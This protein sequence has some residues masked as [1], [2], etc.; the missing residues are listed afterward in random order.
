MINPQAQ[1]SNSSKQRFFYGY[2][3]VVVSFCIIL[4]LVGTQFSFGIFFKPVL[5]EFG[6]TRA[7]TS[8]AFSLSMIINGLLCIVMGGFNDKFGPR[9]V[10]TLCGFIFGLGYLLMSRVNTIWQLYLFYGV[11]IGIGMSGLWVPTMSTVARW[12]TRR[13]GT[14]TGIVLGGTG[15][16]TFILSQLASRLIA[17]YDWRISYI[18]IGSFVLVVLVALAQLLRRDPAQIGQMPYGESAESGRKVELSNKGFSLSEAVRIRQFW[19]IIIMYLCSGYVLNTIMVHIVPHVTDLGISPISA[20][21]IL[22][23]I[24][25]IGIVSRFA[26]GSIADRIGNKQATIISFTMMSTALL[27]LLLINEMWMFYLFAGIY[28]LSVGIGALWSPLIAE[29]FGLKSHGLIFGVINL[30]FSIGASTGPLL[31]GYMFDNTDS[32]RIAFLICFAI[33][34]ASIIIASLLRPPV[35]TVDY[36]PPTNLLTSLTLLW[37]D[38]RGSGQYPLELND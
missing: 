30:G 14:M 25:G 1:Q 31:A 2:I 32:Y 15:S 11:I 18:I 33:S 34:I 24:G 16:G 36:P 13:R 35:K 8:G 38:F 3:I 29:Y 26:V 5:N 9:V 6:W 20:A 7:M 10:I 12:F 27:C 28:G 17:T 37:I 23:A 4:L 21:N 22:A 19:S